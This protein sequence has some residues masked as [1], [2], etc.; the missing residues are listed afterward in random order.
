MEF[1]PGITEKLKKPWILFLIKPWKEK[2]AAIHICTKEWLLTNQAQFL[3]W[4]LEVKKDMT[5]L[6][7]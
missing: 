4:A 6:L 7:F 1:S 5:T 2:F 3:K